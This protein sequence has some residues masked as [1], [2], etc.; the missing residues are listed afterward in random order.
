MANHG[1]LKYML[2]AISIAATAAFAN[3]DIVHTVG[4]GE[5]LF[6]LA[7]KYGV[8]VEQLVKWNP[9][10][11]RGIKKGMKIV[12][13]DGKSAAEESA[14]QSVATSEPEQIIDNTPKENHNTIVT[15]ADTAPTRKT[16]ED[17]A[18]KSDAKTADKIY[19][20]KEGDTFK[21]IAKRTGLSED[22]LMELNP[23]IDPDKIGP[24][25]AVRLTDDAPF[26]QAE[27]SVVLTPAVTDMQTVPADNDANPNI[28]DYNYT[29][30]Q[31][32]NQEVA[33]SVEHKRNIMILLPFMAGAESQPRQAQ[34]YTDFY[35]GF[36][37]A[38]KNHTNSDGDKVEVITLDSNNDIEQLQR[39]LKFNSHR[40][41]AAIIAP[42]DEKQLS[43]II[44]YASDNGIYTINAFNFKNEAFRT[45]PMVIQANIDQ[46][47]MYEKAIQGLMTKYPDHIPV[48]LN[49][50]GAKAEKEAFTNEL[51]AKY[52]EKGIEPVEISFEE[53]LTDAHLSSLDPF[54]SYVF[55]PKSGAL[56]IFNSIAPAI[57]KLQNEAGGTDHYMLFGYPDWTAYRGEALDLLHTLNAVIYSRFYFNEEDPA[58][59]NL[60]NE[61]V[62]WYGQMPIEA[63][64]NQAV[65]G[66]DLGTFLIGG[67]QQGS[68]MDALDDTDFRGV[69][70]AFSFARDDDSEQSGY[71]NQALYFIRYNPDNTCSVTVL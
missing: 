10:T 34:Y 69:Q 8:S 31:T 14:P 58:T 43:A 48:I 25:Q 27:P 52:R 51:V 36:L 7:N 50:V 61:F 2:A 6:G 33:D 60:S 38:A 66:F 19:V 71:V 28:Y 4:K 12:I 35:R 18:E 13:K 41:I 30:E 55:I 5:T 16:T 45:N 49:A 22:R 53:A 1:F 40:D 17:A 62:E 23:F 37:L 57:H 15:D 9:N 29:T 11:E 44:D 32:P 54:A 68:I 65:L 56:G 64:P 39:Q 26:F 46:S 3:A 20:T 42:E 59:K 21:K 67:L 47:L 63:V 24:R 70:S